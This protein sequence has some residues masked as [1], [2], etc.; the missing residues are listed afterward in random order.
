[1]VKATLVGTVALCGGRE[2][3]RGGLAG[4]PV[5]NDLIGEF[6]SLAEI[7]HARPLDGTDVDKYVLAAIIRLDEAEPLMLLNH[8][9]VPLFMGALSA[10]YE[11]A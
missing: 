9:T 2:L 6:L 11:C 8:F 3:V 1:M 10:G 4:L 7:R 5:M